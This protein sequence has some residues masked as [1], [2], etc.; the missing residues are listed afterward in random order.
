MGKRVFP[1]C[2]GNIEPRGQMKRYVP[3]T[4]GCDGYVRRTYEEHRDGTATRTYR[5][6]RCAYYSEVRD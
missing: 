4:E 1:T 2:P 3:G 5:C 6:V